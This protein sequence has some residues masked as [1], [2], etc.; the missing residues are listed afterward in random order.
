MLK[1]HKV[2]DYIEKDAL[3]PDQE[4]YVRKSLLTLLVEMFNNGFYEFSHKFTKNT[5]GFLNY[6]LSNKG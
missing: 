6:C 3:N 1:K 4:F 2:W 5:I